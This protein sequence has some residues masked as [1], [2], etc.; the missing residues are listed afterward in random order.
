M[1]AITGL[2]RARSARQV[3]FRVKM[4]FSPTWLAI[5]NYNSGGIVSSAAMLEMFVAITQVLI[6]RL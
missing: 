3:E 6:G 5:V 4:S 1:E 2:T